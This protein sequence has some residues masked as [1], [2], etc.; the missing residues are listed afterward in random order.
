MHS[1]ISQVP[2][3]SFW[4]DVNSDRLINVSLKN[5]HDTL[6]LWSCFV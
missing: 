6:N 5:H 3:N 1:L 4:E 2:V